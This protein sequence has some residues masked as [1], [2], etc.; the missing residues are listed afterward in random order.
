MYQNGQSMS[1]NSTS[2]NAGGYVASD[3]A[4]KV[5]ALYENLDDDLKAVIKTVTIQCND[6]LTYYQTGNAETATHD[7]TCHLFL[8]SATEVGFDTSSKPYPDSY[9][10]EGEAFAYFL[11]TN[12]LPRVGGCVLLSQPRRLSSGVSTKTASTSGTTLSPRTLS[13]PLLSSASISCDYTFHNFPKL[14]K[15]Y[16]KRTII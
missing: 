15:K 8:A 1:M 3:L 6:G 9:T 10:A 4:P 16:Y 5:E 14:S 2:T 7:Y 12:S 13:C 11:T